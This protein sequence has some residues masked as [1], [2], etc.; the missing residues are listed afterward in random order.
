MR[1][2]ADLNVEDRIT[3]ICLAKNGVGEAIKKFEDYFRSEV[4]AIK[5]PFGEVS[6]ELTKE[7]SVGGEKVAFGISRAKS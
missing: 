5:L 3:V 2:E 4:L 6:G 1:K 7:I